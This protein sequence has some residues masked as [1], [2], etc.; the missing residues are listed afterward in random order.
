MCREL[1]GSARISHLSYSLQ[2]QTAAVQSVL[3]GGGSRW[4]FLG[5][6]DEV[7][8][9]TNNFILAELYKESVRRCEYDGERAGSEIGETDRSAGRISR[10]WSLDGLKRRCGGE[11]LISPIQIVR[12]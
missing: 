4:L 7:P 3:G 9:S 1:E 6:R 2:L 12:E 10:K 8:F 11:Q 5:P